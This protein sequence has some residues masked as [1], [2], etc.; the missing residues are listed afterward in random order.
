[1]VVVNDEPDALRRVALLARNGPHWLNESRQMSDPMD[2]LSERLLA[3]A[4]A[5]EDAL[6]GAP[7]LD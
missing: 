7:V 2:Y 5:A 3:L 6:A 1:M 4:E